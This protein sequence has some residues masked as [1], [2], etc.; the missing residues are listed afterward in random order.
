MLQTITYQE[1]IE[2]IEEKSCVKPGTLDT[3]G[4]RLLFFDGGTVNLPVVKETILF[5]FEVSKQ[6][7]ERPRNV[8]WDTIC[9]VWGWDPKTGNELSRL[10]KLCRD[11]KLKGATPGWIIAIKHEYEKAWPK[12]ESSPE[13]I[14]K[15]WDTFKAKVHPEALKSFSDEKPAAAESS[16]IIP[17]KKK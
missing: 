1:V 8:I 16:R 10:G 3:Y 2:L 14:L 17:I 9:Q 6:K 12:T 15:H 7:K 4:G 5:Q 13:A 11:M